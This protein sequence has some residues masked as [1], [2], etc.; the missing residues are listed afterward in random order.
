MLLIKFLCAI[1]QQGQ[2]LG[3][4]T[5][6]PKFQDNI[7]ISGQHGNFRNVTTTGTPVMVTAKISDER[8]DPRLTGSNFDRLVNLQ[9]N[10]N[11]IQFGIL[12]WLAT[13]QALFLGTKPVP[14]C[15]TD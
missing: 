7:E 2:I 3:H 10:S 13:E 4:F 11:Y 14:L 15:D 8:N 6:R 5:N 1:Q 9:S 12:P